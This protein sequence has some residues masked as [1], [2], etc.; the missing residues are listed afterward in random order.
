LLVVLMF[1]GDREGNAGRTLKA[2]GCSDGAG[3]KRVLTPGACAC[4]PLRFPG[5]GVRAIGAR[6]ALNKT[7]LPSITVL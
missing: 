5:V 6:C 3:G 1:T 4:V 2:C 7:E